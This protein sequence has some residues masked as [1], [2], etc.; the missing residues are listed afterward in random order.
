MNRI[1]RDFPFNK[2]DFTALRSAFTGSD[3]TTYFFGDTSYVRYD[4]TQAQFTLKTPK[5]IKKD[6]GRVQNNFVQYQKVDAAVALPD[7]VTY[8]FSGDQ[9]VRYSGVNYRHAD[10]GYPKSL[11]GNLRKE[12][13]FSHLSD[14]FEADLSNRIS[15][16]KTNKDKPVMDGVVANTRN[17]TVFMGSKCYVASQTLTHDYGISLIGRLRNNIAAYNRIDDAFVSGAKDPATGNDKR[18]TYLLC[19][20]QY[21]RYSGSSYDYVDDGYPKIIA[22]GL[23]EEIEGLN[24]LPEAFTYDLDAAVGGGKQPIYLFKGKEFLA[25]QPGAK[26]QAINTRWGKT[27]NPFEANSKDGQGSID[28][29]FLAPAG[30]F[31]FFKDGQYIRYQSIDQEF[32]DQGYPKPIKDNWGNLPIHFEQSI[33][34][35]FVF[36]DK[37][38]F[39][40]DQDYVR[41]S[42]QS[43]QEIDSIYPQKFIDRWAGWADYLLNDLALISHFKQLNDTYASGEASLSLFLSNQGEAIENPYQMLSEIFDWDIDELKWLKR[44]N[45]FLGGASL[46]EQK[47][48]LELILRINEQFILANKMAVGPSDIYQNTWQKLYQNDPPQLRP[49]ADALSRYLGLANGQKEWKDLSA[50]LHGELNLLK[51]DALLPYVITLLKEQGVDNA[52]DLYEHFLID[53][54]MGSDGITSRIKEALAATQLYFHRYFVNLEPKASTDNKER[55]STWWQWMKNYRVWEAN[56][57]V[58]LYPENYIRPELRR[59][60]TPAFKTLEQDLLQG[61]IDQDSVTQ[62]YKKYLDEYT[63]VSRLTIAGGYVYRPGDPKI[64]EKLVLFGRTKTDPRRYYYRM[65]SFVKD[66]DA[67][68]WEPWLDINQKIDADKVYP[69]FAFNRVFV[70]WASLE[71]KADSSSK[72]EMTLK[73][74]GDDKQT[75]S[76][77]TKVD[78]IINIHFSFYNLNKEWVTPQTFSQHIKESS[79]IN[80][81]NIKLFVENAQKFSTSIEQE[82][83]V[84][85]CS[86]TTD[87]SK[88]NNKYKSF[89]LTP[90]LKSHKIE[91]AKAF[92]DRG[93]KAFTQIFDEPENADVNVVMLNSQ[94]ES[95]QADWFSFDYKGGCFLCRPNKNPK[96]SNS[97]PLT[98]LKGNKNNFPEW[99][100][101]D[102]AFNWKGKDYFFNNSRLG[103]EPQYSYRTGSTGQLSEPAN[104]RDRW[105]RVRNNIIQTG[106]IDAGLSIGNKCYLFSGDEYLTY[107]ISQLTSVGPKLADYGCPLLLSNNKESLPKWQKIDAAFVGFDGKYYFFN[108]AKKQFVTLEDKQLSDPQSIDAVFGKRRQTETSVTNNIATAGKIDAAFTKTQG[109]KKYTY[110]CSGDQYVRYTGSAYQYI[111]EGY[112]KSLQGNEEGIPEW[113]NSALSTNGYVWFFNNTTKQYAE[114]AQSSNFKPTASD[115]G[116]VRNNFTET[117]RV[118]AAF[119]R[120]N[121]LF[122]ISGNQFI[123]YSNQQ[124]LPDYADPGYPK[125]YSIQGIR[126]I[127][128]AFVKRGKVLLFGGGS[129][130]ELPPSSELDTQIEA[131]PIRG[132]W[133]NFPPSLSQGISAAYQD[134]SDLFLFK[135]SQYIKYGQSSL[136]KE[137]EQ[138][139]YKIVRLT[140][141]TAYK[142]NETLF[143]KGVPG[144][145]SI[146]TQEINELPAFTSNQ[147]SKNQAY[148]PTLITYKKDKVKYAPVSSHLDFSSANGIYYWEIFFHAPFL[149]ANALNANKK[150]QGYEYAKE[151]YEFLFDPTRIGDYWRFLPFLST[152]VQALIDSI[153]HE[154]Q[155][156]K[157][158]GGAQDLEPLF[159]PLLSKLQPWVQLFQ[160]AEAL[161]K[162]KK[163]ESDFSDLRQKL[164]T[165]SEAL[166]AKTEPLANTL[167]QKESQTSSKEAKRCLNTLQELVAIIDRLKIRYDI[168]VYNRP[169]QINTYLDDLANPHAIAALRPIAYRKTI[170]MAYVDN[171]LDWGDALFRQYTRE[172]INEARMLYILAYDLLGQKPQNLGKKILPAEQPYTALAN[173]NEYEFVIRTQF[174]KPTGTECISLLTGSRE[175]S[176]GCPYFFIPQNQQFLDYWDRVQDRLY[177]IRHSLNILGIKQP[178]PLFQP[179]ID[180]MALVQAMASGGSIGSVLAG[181]GAPV[182]HY[183]FSFMLNKAQELVQSLSN[184][185]GSL[186]SALQQKDAE[187][188]IILQN[189]QEAALQEIT[190]K[191]NQEELENAK[192]TTLQYQ[193]NQASAQKQLQHYTNLIEKGKLPSEIKQHDQ[194]NTSMKHQKASA[195]GKIASTI[196]YALPQVKLGLFNFGTELGGVELGTVIDKAAEA[197]D[198]TSQALSISAEMLGIQAQFERTVQDWELQKL[199]VDNEIEQLNYQITGAKIQEKIAQ[200]NIDSTEKQIQQTKDTGDFLKSKFTNEELYQWMASKLSS[201]CYQTYQLAYDYAKAAEKAYQYEKGVKP[202]DANFIK[203]NYWDTARKGQLAGESLSLD[204]S[205]MEQAYLNTDERTLEIT[206]SINLSEL[207]PVALLRLKELGSCEF[208]FT[209]ARLDRDFPGHYCRQIRTLSVTFK[210]DKG[211]N[212]SVN[213]TLTQLTHKTLLE[214]DPKAV[215]Y[216]LNPKDLPPE[217][218]RQDWRPS[219]QIA[220]SAITSG[221]YNPG[222]G[223]F[224]LNYRD[225]R[226]LPFEGTGAISTWRLELGGSTT[227]YQKKDFKDVTLQ[228]RYAASNGG[229]AFANSVKGLLKPYTTATLF[230]MA[231]D[232]PQAWK[233]FLTDQTQDLELSLTRQ[234]FPHISSSKISGILAPG[235]R[236][237]SLA[238]DQ[239]PVGPGGLLPLGRFGYGG[240]AHPGQ[241]IPTQSFSITTEAVILRVATQAPARTG[242]SSI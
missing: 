29:A 66:K 132:S 197:L 2:T 12:V 131:K 95:S 74:D 100:R 135:G 101:I 15:T 25:L 203:P 153:Q 58:F 200:Y 47:Q 120:N 48:Q 82:N 53:V 161:Y 149:I 222:H 20:D 75:F 54:E 81:D 235:L 151:W 22:A 213:A 184:L 99:N 180:P 97:L 43:Y 236:L 56:R 61:E 78:C 209:E 154:L 103:K 114:R 179:P 23:A 71:E 70:F 195:I 14:A 115:W 118:D 233:A 69:V 137:V 242:F 110:L 62:A 219:Q 72:Q 130:A 144:L 147:E 162:V 215:K 24:Q 214:P 16:W 67:G 172:T 136:P 133:D 240:N 3:G 192:Q 73:K 150:P 37:T 241:H 139:D 145:L 208:A 201:L 177:K 232:F 38:Y 113:I 31:Y 220:L 186:L 227:A 85:N 140:S 89:R 41:Y 90:D 34:G 174:S 88:H 107:T 239:H 169:A 128:A 109:G 129:Y 39:C 173:N 224:D 142:L 122:L 237:C 7:G 170:V 116:M 6:W 141:S 40:K 102:A 160:E 223:L 148:N 21:V 86:Y 13:A 59:D 17:I 44:N 231:K 1:W 205:R 46:F 108:N 18:K 175:T 106:Q 211:E 27:N 126:P 19:G 176:I 55:L 193:E 183:R 178:L 93:K 8:L 190:L 35:A 79:P 112:P 60:K 210:D 157:K 171:L 146:E 9:Y 206:K 64:D 4:N 57:K 182:P 124:S 123:R 52:R 221:D 155:K 33:D 92:P 134:K 26:P 152:D 164:T 68:I 165:A 226:Y 63:E 117:G 77:D 194:M 30:G 225:D 104:T 158:L 185:A 228:L 168:L 166:K 51:R 212:M 217:T 11:Q 156:L 49:A 36:K 127:Q 187:H 119:V 121:S 50:Q 10:E 189:Q 87:S 45:A 5:T 76:S 94:E 202:S 207:D 199:M 83:I 96:T 65:A 84:I 191:I 111:D 91:E 181:L 196:L 218:L 105:G 138:I 238:K 198:A 143:A 98:P 230:E 229:Q 216:L 163:Q 167:K 42:D 234:Q 32:I 188:L 80:K 204:L 28:A 159:Q 125:Q